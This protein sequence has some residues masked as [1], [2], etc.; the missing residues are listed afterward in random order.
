MGMT[1]FQA[2]YGRPPPT[3]PFYHVGSSPVNEVDQAL[4][5]R[6]D[7]L[8]QLKHN[9]AMATNRM[10]Q[11]ADK[12]RRDVEFQSGDLVFLKLQP[13][14]QSSVFKRANKKLACIYFGPYKI[15]RKIGPVAYKLQLPE[16]SRIHPVFH[17]SLLKKAIGDFSS[18]TDLPSIDDEGL[19]VMEPLAILDTRWLRRGGKVVEQQLVQWKRLPVEDATWEDTELLQ[20]QFPHMT[21]EDKGTF[22]GEGNDKKQPQSLEP[23]KSSRGHKPNPKYVT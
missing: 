9:L 17:V 18:S 8:R 4:L 5:T 23:R 2:L 15:V 10:K 14:K 20:R 6:D 22:R 7:L 21:L 16:S 12:R 1:P 3:V 11:V 19:I 13:Y